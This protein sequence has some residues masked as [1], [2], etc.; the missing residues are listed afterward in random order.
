MGESLP[1]LE[2]PGPTIEARKS[3]QGETLATPSQQ[4]ELPE[5]PPLPSISQFQEVFG[6]RPDPIFLENLEERNQDLERTF[7]RLKNIAHGQSDYYEQN[8]IKEGIRHINWRKENFDFQYRSLPVLI[9]AHLW[10]QERKTIS[11]WRKKGIKNAKDIVDSL[12]KRGS[13]L[14]GDGRKS[15]NYQL[16]LEE[17][18]IN[19]FLD[20]QE[21]GVD[22]GRALEQAEILI[23]GFGFTE[24]ANSLPQEL[25]GKR[26]QTVFQECLATPNNTITR[27]IEQLASLS[28]FQKIN[29]EIIA[30]LRDRG[31]LSEEQL[32]ALEFASFLGIGSVEDCLQEPN[33]LQKYYHLLITDDCL[34]LCQHGIDCYHYFRQQWTN[35]KSAEVLQDEIKQIKEIL[36]SEK[37]SYL[38]VVLEHLE[39]S[40][41]GSAQMIAKHL[42]EMLEVTRFVE[43]EQTTNPKVFKYI[44]KE[45]LNKI[46]QAKS[47]AEFLENWEN[48]IQGNL[49]DILTSLYLSHKGTVL[50]RDYPQ[51]TKRALSTKVPVFDLLWRCP[52]ITTEIPENIFSNLT[53][54]EQSL[55]KFF[56]NASSEIKNA[57]CSSSSYFEKLFNDGVPRLL[58]TTSSFWPQ[59]LAIGNES[60]KRKILEKISSIDSS[61]LSSPE[62]TETWLRIIL[63]I[64]KTKSAEIKKAAEKI[65]QLV[66][67]SDSPE[68]DFKQIEEIFLT[69]NVPYVVRVFKV[70]E[71]LYAKKNQQIYSPVL[72]KASLRRMKD[73]VYRD[74]LY[75]HINSGNP[76]LRNYVNALLKIEGL[77]SRYEENSQDLTSLERNQ[78][79]F[80]LKK[81][82]ALFNISLL[83]KWK[84]QKTTRDIDKDIDDEIEQLKQD[85]E[86]RENQSITQRLAEMFLRPLGFESLTEIEE[87][88]NK[89]KNSA[90]QR[91]LDYATSGL[92]LAPG[93]L[94]KG[95][96]YQ[97]LENLLQNGVVA[98]NF[99]GENA[100]E[101]STP[102]DTDASMLKKENFQGETEEEIFQNALESLSSWNYGNGLILVIKNR[103]QFHISNLQKSTK[104]SITKTW[105]PNELFPTA[106]GFGIRTGL[107]STEIDFI[108]IQ[109]RLLSDQQSLRK[110]F[111]AIAQNGF[112]IPVANQ[113]G[114]I[115]FTPK[116]FEE[117][118][119]IYEPK[120][121]FSD[122]EEIFKKPTFNPEKLISLLQKQYPEIYERKVGVW[123]GYTLKEHSLTVLKLFEKYFANRN[124]PS[125]IDKNMF[126]L[127]LA[128][129]DVG[130]PEAISKG[131]KHLQHEYTQAYIRSL[132]ESLNIDYGFTRLALALASDDPIGKYLTYR[133]GV[134][135]TRETIE[136]MALEAEM[137]TDKFFELLCLY[138]KLDAG[139]YTEN[140][141]GKKSLDH[142]FKFDDG[143]LSFAPDTEARISLLRN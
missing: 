131:G 80:G 110:I 43:I 91:G 34:S 3:S 97:Y 44:Y 98:K 109:D 113:R 99:L 104:E 92:K 56:E 100:N 129:H 65:F 5:A 107:P 87:A 112:Y 55:A 30:T 12:K 29:P 15:Y 24:P 50:W 22:I 115:I 79:R 40:D 6:F 17:P 66:I 142:L 36:E 2:Q 128:L 63:R 52:P 25:F 49:T 120:I 58:E 32:K 93:D 134:E 94:T 127:F 126:R 138:Y 53:P 108:I 10:I 137:P 68:A 139:S 70:F 61:L 117:Y 14:L 9:K 64:G 121:E 114:E 76:S 35:R 116:M 72:K 95:T 18:V 106:F 19:F 89:A 7:S 45:K 20:H 31:E 57:L 41:F 84:D 54:E 78:L 102:L 141:G 69:N 105:R 136:R 67:D 4:K 33:L 103:G 46:G 28:Y 42:E 88:I 21:R 133:M 125:G 26:T 82:R 85:L 124:L 118:R 51:L 71:L 122:L 47:V 77:I 119:Q 27:L 130:K 11:T 111:S 16:L 38:W 8:I 123:E 59:F 132:F 23:G 75:V 135:Q 62:N 60:L 83:G 73:I 48:F 90:H 143:E 39:T 37:G 101:D 74:L 1:E 86:V 13:R 96:E 140:A 81:I